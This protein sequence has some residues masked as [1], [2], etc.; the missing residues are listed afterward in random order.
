VE[1]GVQTLDDAALAL[2]R[3]GHD[4]GQA[5]KACER[6]MGAGLRCV[7]QL[8]AGLPGAG[9]ASDEATARGIAAL[10]PD[11]VRIHPTLVLQGTELEDQLRTGRWTPPDL[12]E[13]VLR[14]AAMVEILEAAGVNVIRLGIQE[15]EGLRERV[16]AGAWHPAFGELVRGE[17]LAGRLFRELGPVDASVEV[18]RREA[19]QLLGHGRR[20]LRRLEAL[21]GRAVAVVIIK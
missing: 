16:V 10:R 7:V 15:I 14:V 17:L 9:R 5:L 8:M 20:G 4:A 12:D 18:P 13:A 3:R 2:A 11:G 19:S 6:V 1:I 21:A